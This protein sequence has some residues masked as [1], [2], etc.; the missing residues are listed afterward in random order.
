MDK[1]Q[2]DFIVR[3]FLCLFKKY[4]PSVCNMK[5]F[6]IFAT[7]NTLTNFNMKNN[8]FLTKILCFL[9]IIC[10][11]LTLNSCTA[12]RRSSVK[13]NKQKYS[14]QKTRSKQPN[15]NTNTSLQTKYVIKDKR[16]TKFHY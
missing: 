1:I 2:A 8:L 3:H 11:V 12:N 4:F 15:W 13:G 6:C 7:Q 9:G 5:I 10:L 14:Y 16:R